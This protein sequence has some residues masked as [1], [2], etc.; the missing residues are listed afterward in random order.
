[1]VEI[2]SPNGKK[3]TVLINVIDMGYYLSPLALVKSD[4]KDT[5]NIASNGIH[6]KI[7]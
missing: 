4:S 1:M 7:V 5:L 3:N 2:L 6:Y